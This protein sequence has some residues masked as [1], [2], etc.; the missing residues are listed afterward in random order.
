MLIGGTTFRNFYSFTDSD[1]PAIVRAPEFPRI[2]ESLCFYGINDLRI[3]AVLG[4]LDIQ[5]FQGTRNSGNFAVGF[6]VH[7]FKGC[8]RNFTF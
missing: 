1:I 5:N 7:I 4:G 6:Y 2:L 3:C 8:R